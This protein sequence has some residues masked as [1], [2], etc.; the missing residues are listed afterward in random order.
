MDGTAVTVSVIVPA[1]N[2]A[3]WIGQA[4]HSVFR[5]TL[6]DWE[7]I[8]IDDA[9]SDETWS[10]I[11]AY[12]RPLS[13]ENGRITTIRH[14]HNQ[15]APTTLNEGMALAQGEY[16]AILN[17]DDAWQPERLERMVR[18]ARRQELDFLVTGLTLWDRDAGCKDE[19]EPDWLKWYRSLYADWLSHGDFLRT[20]LRGNFFITT[21]NFFFLR[22]LFDAHGGFA[23]LRY[24]HDYEYALRLFGKGVK[25]QCLWD[26]KLLNYRLHDH[27]TIREKPLAAIEEN[28]LMLLEQLPEL[29]PYLDY[30][31][32]EGLKLQLQDLQR[33]TREEWLSAI[34]YQLLN[35]EKELF[36]LIYDRDEWI[37]ERDE[38]IS[39]QQILISD[40][41]DW[42]AERDHT[43]NTLQADIRQQEQNLQ[44]RDRIISGQQGWIADR[45]R[46]ITE[47]DQWIAERDQLIRERDEHIHKLEQELQ[48]LLH[49]RAYR[50]GTLLA[51]PIR[52]LR[53]RLHPDRWKF[54]HA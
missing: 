48:R 49:S 40:R 9:S 19:S 32:L 42:I 44:E 43:I 30:S 31:R 8:L 47:R 29:Y 51:W 5:Q 38:I 37:Q 3:A 36:G 25:M 10:V 23:N 46:W 54:N 7:L 15:G 27:N 6:T 16:I 24:V 39:N 12:T 45:D 50:T 18:F 14:T 52:Q 41:D 26:E 28:M 17:S 13:S 53:G 34:H 4:I 22:H 20:L 35:K 33:Y 2:H 21:S 11:Q 1:Y